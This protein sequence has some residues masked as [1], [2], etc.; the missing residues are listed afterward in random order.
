MTGPD[1]AEAS[2]ARLSAIVRAE[3]AIIVASLAR[4]IG[5]VDVAEE[6]TAAAIE[7]ALVQWR[8][9][10]IPPRPGAW[11]SL[12]A[13]HNALDL[14]RRERVG[15]QKLTMIE[16]EWRGVDDGDADSDVDDRVP[17]LFGCCHPALAPESQ[18][19][20]TLRAVLG[21]T[22]AQ[23]ARTTF[24][25]EATVGQRISRAKRKVGAAG[26]ALRIPEGPERAERLDIVLTVISVMYSAAHL[27]PA[28]GADT[29]R[30][31]A[32]DAIWLAGVVARTFP[33]SAETAGLRACCCSTARASRREP[34][35][36]S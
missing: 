25:P 35:T 15:R 16:S 19:A 10:G 33:D 12:A 7:D 22:T 32:E 30:D 6:A 18:L 21:V 5:S 13:R 9:S 27:A 31:L 23:I 34:S 4:R 20:L 24:E 1:A 36:T 17:L 26:I 14:M 29:D 8:R 3:A 11:L 2:D 28:R